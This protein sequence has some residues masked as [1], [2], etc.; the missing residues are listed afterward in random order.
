LATDSSGNMAV[1]LT[2]L[3]DQEECVIIALNCAKMEVSK[4][5]YISYFNYLFFCTTDTVP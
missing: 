1:P 2:G 5:P 4:C 3:A